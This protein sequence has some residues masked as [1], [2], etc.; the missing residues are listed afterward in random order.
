[1]ALMAGLDSHMAFTRALPSTSEYYSRCHDLL[2]SS[3][4]LF[5]SITALAPNGTDG[6]RKLLL[7]DDR[8]GKDPPMFVGAAHG[9]SFGIWIAKC[10]RFCTSAWP[11]TPPTWMLAG[12]RASFCDRPTML[13]PTSTG[14][15]SVWRGS[16][17]SRFALAM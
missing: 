5:I 11:R 6:L 12:W 4:R 16:R 15:C 17:S 3:A 13:Q 9:G 1:M 2:D 7:K 10:L 14:G 8:A